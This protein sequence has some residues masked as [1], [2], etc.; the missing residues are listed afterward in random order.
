MDAALRL[1][2]SYTARSKRGIGGQAALNQIAR[3]PY[4]LDLIAEALDPM[5]IGLPTEP[6]Q[7]PLGEVAMSL[8]RR[9]NPK[10][11]TSKS[12]MTQ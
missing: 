11:L 10:K 1:F 2:A 3:F 4:R 5:H 9:S 12:F 7:L 8:L 6:R